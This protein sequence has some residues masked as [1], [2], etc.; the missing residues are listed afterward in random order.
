[1]LHPGDCSK[2][3]R[4]RLIKL[5]DRLSLIPEKEG[6][7]RTRKNITPNEPGVEK[8]STTYDPKPL[9]EEDA[10][11]QCEGLIMSMVGSLPTGVVR[12][13]DI[14]VYGEPEPQC[15]DI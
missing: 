5:E 13:F 6:Y 8:H 10:A 15:S 11:I 2:T 14:H 9:S 12:D 3:H 1:M 7:T 4:E